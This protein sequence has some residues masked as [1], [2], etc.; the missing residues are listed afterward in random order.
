MVLQHK[1]NFYEETC[2]EYLKM[3]FVEHIPKK[4]QINFQSRQKHNILKSIWLI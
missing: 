2:L 1:L 4:A 3:Y